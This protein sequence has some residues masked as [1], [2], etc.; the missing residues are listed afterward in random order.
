[1]RRSSLSILIG[2][3][4]PYFPALLLPSKSQGKSLSHVGLYLLSPVFNNGQLY[5]ALSGV[6]S[7]KGLKVLICDEEGNTYD[8]TTNVVYKEVLDKL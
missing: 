5:V 7:R 6:I 8:T 2:D 3:S 1:M 4:S